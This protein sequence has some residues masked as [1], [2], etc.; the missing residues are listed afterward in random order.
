MLFLGAMPGEEM[1]TVHREAGF[2]FFFVMADVSAE[3]PE[4]VHVEGHEGFAKVWLR[5]LSFA[6]C[7]GYNPAQKGEILRIVGRKRSAMLQKWDEERARSQ[8]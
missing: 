4:H 6:S 2:R 7:R 8:S 3:E 1:P 5:D